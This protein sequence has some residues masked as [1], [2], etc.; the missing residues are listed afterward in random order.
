LSFGFDGTLR[1]PTVSASPAAGISFFVEPPRL[2]RFSREELL[3][4]VCLY[5]LVEAGE[6]ID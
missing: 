6:E 1:R 3:R 2:Q 4:A 5:A